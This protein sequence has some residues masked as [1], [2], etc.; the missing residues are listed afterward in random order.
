MNKISLIIKREYLTRVKKK[1]FIIMTLI[2]PLLMAGL[3]SV[4][5]WLAT[6][7]KD[8]PRIDVIDE[9]GAFI[10][11]FENTAELQFKNEFISIEKAKA[12]LYNSVYTSILYIKDVEE[13]FNGDRDSYNPV[14]SLVPI[15]GIVAWAKTWGI[16]DFGTTDGTAAFKLIQSGQNFTSTILVG[17]IVHNSTDGTFANVTN[18]K[19]FSSS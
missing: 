18:V 15:G 6:K 16:A 13:T 9:T 1:S 19:L 4:P 2:G 3:M 10:N 17:M 7:D 8:I 11:Q 5:I 12:N 14:P